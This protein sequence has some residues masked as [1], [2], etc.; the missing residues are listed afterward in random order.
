MKPICSLWETTGFGIEFAKFAL[1]LKS[2]Y[3]PVDKR[4]TSTVTT[5]AEMRS[6]E[7]LLIHFVIR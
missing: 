6:A 3:H 2:F 1:N 4:C 5:T 7:K